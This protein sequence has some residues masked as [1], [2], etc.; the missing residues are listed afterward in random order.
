[1]VIA[2]HCD[3]LLFQVL[4]AYFLH[5]FADLHERNCL[6]LFASVLLA[7][8]LGLSFVLCYFVAVV[9]EF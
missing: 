5:G 1:M 4:V 2:G 7:V 9:V 8:A 3:Y 6:W